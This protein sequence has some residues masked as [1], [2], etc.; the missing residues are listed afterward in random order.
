LAILTAI[1]RASSRA[2]DQAYCCVFF[3]PAP[4]GVFGLGVLGAGRMAPQGSF[5]F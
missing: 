3:A 1:L 4:V 5:G 2:K